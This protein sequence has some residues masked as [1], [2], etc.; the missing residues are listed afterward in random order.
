MTAT[1]RGIHRDRAEYLRKYCQTDC[2]GSNEVREKSRIEFPAK[3]NNA[4]CWTSADIPLL[5]IY[6]YVCMYI[7]GTAVL[8]IVLPRKL[9]ITQLNWRKGSD[10][11]KKEVKLNGRL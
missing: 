4:I 1:K 6:I 10:H 2:R 3:W 7:L 11:K 9:R 5:S 8:V